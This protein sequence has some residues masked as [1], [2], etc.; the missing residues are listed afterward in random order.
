MNHWGLTWLWKYLNTSFT[1]NL[2]AF[3]SYLPNYQNSYTT[4]LNTLYLHTKNNTYKHNS[5]F[6]RFVERFV[7]K[8][9]VW[10]WKMPLEMLLSDSRLLWYD[11]WC[12]LRTLFFSYFYRHFLKQFS[13]WLAY[14]PF[15]IF[16]GIFKYSTDYL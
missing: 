10:Q 6:S 3:I 12:F 1:R 5:I 4:F 7:H 15:S 8:W 13:Y 2:K 14:N 9:T 16:H 11:K